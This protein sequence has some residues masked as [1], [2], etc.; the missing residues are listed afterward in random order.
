VARTTTQAGT[1]LSPADLHTC[2]TLL[3]RCPQ[4][5]PGADI[6]VV[7]LDGRIA[8]IGT[9]AQ[10]AASGV[11]LA[12][13]MPELPAGVAAAAAAGDSAGGNGAFI[14]D[15]EEL[16]QQS[17]QQQQFEQQQQSG[18]QQH[19]DPH[20]LAPAAAVPLPVEQN[21][22]VSRSSVVNN[23]ANGHSSNDSCYSDDSD[24]DIDD[25]SDDEEADTS[26]LAARL[27]CSS[28]T[29][30]KALPSRVGVRTDS[31][32]LVFAETRARGRVSRAVYRAYLSAWGPAYLLPLAVLLGAPIPPLQQQ[33]Q[34]QAQ[35]ACCSR[36][37]EDHNA[38]HHFHPTHLAHMLLARCCTNITLSL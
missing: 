15:D 38:H 26:R 24:S 29:G 32:R 10:L 9:P 31:G 4:F 2:I 6:V 27:R 17:E 30:A 33:Q 37:R 13:I 18:Q 8:H 14:L 34:Q 25:V 36:S 35:H 7:M 28:G 11:D 12:A 23:T 16:Q 20:H 21:G 22:S 1:P 19:S 3:W 5:V